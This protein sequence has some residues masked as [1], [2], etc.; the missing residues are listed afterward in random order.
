[1][2]IW[3]HF[4]CGSRFLISDI[5]IDPRLGEMLNDPCQVW[6]SPPPTNLRNR[7]PWAKRRTFSNAQKRPG[8][9]WTN[10]SRI[11]EDFSWKTWENRMKMQSK[12]R[13]FKCFI[14]YHQVYSLY[15]ILCVWVLCKLYH[16]VL[17]A[18][19]TCRDFAVSFVKPS[20]HH[21]CQWKELLEKMS[22]Q[23]PIWQPEWMKSYDP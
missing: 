8:F 19:P 10:K 4:V 22:T 11:S 20:N 9:F 12:V 16:F 17:L 18:A 14:K 5:L 1:M 6:A 13:K 3:F 23:V 7:R 15:S 21:L 2:N